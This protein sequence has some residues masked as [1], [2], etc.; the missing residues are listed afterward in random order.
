MSLLFGT[1]PLMTWTLASETGYGQIKMVQEE[2]PP[3]KQQHFSCC[4]D[5]PT[6]Y[7]ASDIPQTELSLTLVS[8]M[9]ILCFRYVIFLS[10]SVQY[11]KTKLGKHL[12]YH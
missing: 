4:F 6:M 2:V 3:S 1:V 11:V 7:V 12:K 5:C 9:L 8:G 10:C